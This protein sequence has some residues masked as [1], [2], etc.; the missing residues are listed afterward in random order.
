MGGPTY[1]TDKEM[2]ISDGRKIVVLV[3]LLFLAFNTLEVD[4]TDTAWG[5]DGI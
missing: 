5:C 1:P 2:M 3:S 4:K